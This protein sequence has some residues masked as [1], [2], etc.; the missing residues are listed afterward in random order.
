MSHTKLETVKLRK[1]APVEIIHVPKPSIYIANFL[2]PVHSGS[3][4]QREQCQEH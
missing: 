1:D 4:V 2:Y 3:S